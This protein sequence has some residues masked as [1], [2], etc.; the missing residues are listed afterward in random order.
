MTLLETK[1]GPI[2]GTTL[3]SST[4]QPISAFRGIPYAVPPVGALR[5]RRS[6]P[7][8]PWPGTL[9]GTRESTKCLQLNAL[10]PTYI[11]RSGPR[12]QAGSEDCLYLN[13]Y[14]RNLPPPPYSDVL[15][16][17]VIFLHGGA[18]VVGS[19]E[20]MLYGPEVLLARD[21]VLVAVNYRLGP[22]GWLSTETDAAPG[23]L[24]LHDQYLALLW[25]RDNIADYGGD[26]ANVT[27]MGESAGAMSA[28]LHTV[29]PV[30]RGLFHKVSTATTEL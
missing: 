22:L 18:F 24:G 4:N 12:L 20:A 29:S 16:P 7:S 14:T 9:D 28:M 8:G 2:K 23:N 13:V 3:Q 5:F 19:N 15:H 26:P 21:L 17:V 11:E 6:R 10:L 25:V 1:L 30:S 27:L